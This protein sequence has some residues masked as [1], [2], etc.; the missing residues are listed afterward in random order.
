MTTPEKTV[1]VE[2]TT[3]PRPAL[4]LLAT[5]ITTGIAVVLAPAAYFT[6]LMA[7][8]MFRIPSNGPLSAAIWLAALLLVAGW[9]ITTAAR[10]VKI[11][12]LAFLVCTI[13]VA[14]PIYAF[15]DDYV[16]GYLVPQMMVIVI[17]QGLGL[18]GWL[19]L[20]GRPGRS[21][22]ALPILLLSFGAVI[23][24]GVVVGWLVLA[25]VPAIAAWVAFLIGRGDGG[26]EKRAS[27][28]T[29]AQASRIEANAQA[30]RDWQAAYEL[31][32]PGQ[33]IPVLPP[34]FLPSAA[35]PL[36]TDHTNTLAVLAFIFGVLGGYLAIVFGHIALSQIK[37]TGERGSRL[38]TA[39]LVLGYAWV[40]GTVVFCVVFVVLVSTL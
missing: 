11:R 6:A 33:P 27:A 1:A 14:L 26:A 19:V 2:P 40:T 28:M 16:S 38:A 4:R 30:I 20:R 10:S 24:P 3:A 36:Q 21:F 8:Q 5:Q 39:G 18:A 12:A 13:I 29:A 17:A 7:R 9:A 35:A 25:L 31:A 23:A 37:R 22:A 32:N 34:N 15:M